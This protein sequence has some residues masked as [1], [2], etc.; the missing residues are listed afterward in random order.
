MRPSPAQIPPI[1]PEFGIARSYLDWLLSLPSGQRPA[2]A[3]YATEDDPFTQPQVDKARSLL[4][5]G[6]IP[7]AY[8]KV[9]PAETTDFTP[10]AKAVA[11]SNADVVVLGTQLP[12]AIA[13]VQTFQAQQYNPKSIVETTGPDQGSDFSDKVG[14][15]NTEGIIVPAGWWPRGP[16]G[17]RGTTATS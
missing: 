16:S 8:Y 12:D 14:K 7:T 10:I 9:Y 6:G 13:F 3:A 17:P 15:A 4:E 11:N 1:S 2:S 5:A